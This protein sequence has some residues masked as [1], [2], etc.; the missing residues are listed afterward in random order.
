M[1]KLLYS[2][3]TH[4]KASDANEVRLCFEVAGIAADENGN[5][6]L[7]GMQIAIGFTD[8]FVDYDDL[9]AD[10]NLDAIAD[11]IPGNVKREDIRVITP[12]E[13]DEKYGDI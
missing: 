9:M 8:K 2:N 1:S 7:A 12:E 4:K 3:T 6:C 10:I 13:Y 5:P 11:M